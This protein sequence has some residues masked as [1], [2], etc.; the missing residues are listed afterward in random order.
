VS[1]G[2]V[3]TALLVRRPVAPEFSDASLSE[4]AEAPAH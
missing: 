4:Q 1:L 3:A 2:I